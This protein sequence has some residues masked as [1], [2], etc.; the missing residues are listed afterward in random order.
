[1]KRKLTTLSAVVLLC[2]ASAPTM[3]NWLWCTGKI[4]HLYIDIHADLHIHSSWRGSYTM[5]CAMDRTWNSVTPDI[6]KA[7]FAMLQGAYHAQSTVIVQYRNPTGSACSELAT[8]TDAPGPN[9]V[10]LR[11]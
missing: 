3:A 9:Y 6:C 8:Y 1:M 11:N 7:W 2:L 5:I 4:N 10:M